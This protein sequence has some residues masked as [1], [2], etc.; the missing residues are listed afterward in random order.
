MQKF[1]LD[2]TNAGPACRTQRKVA[3]PA[4]A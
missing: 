4:T 3:D 2:M 1:F